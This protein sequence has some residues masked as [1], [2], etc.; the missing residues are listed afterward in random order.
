MHAR[1][2]LSFIFLWSIGGQLSAC[3]FTILHHCNQ[4]WYRILHARMMLGNL[5]MRRN[6]DDD[7]DDDDY[8]DDDDESAFIFRRL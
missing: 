4:I 3:K 8:D 6:D 7:D 5:Y 2:D 1:I